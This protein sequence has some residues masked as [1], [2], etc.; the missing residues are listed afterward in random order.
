MT[1][2]IV[3]TQSVTTSPAQAQQR[4]FEETACSQPTALLA[5]PLALHV[6]SSPSSAVR[7]APS[8]EPGM[9][10]DL[11]VP[12]APPLLAVWL[13]SQGAARSSRQNMRC[14]RDS[15]RFCVARASTCSH[16]LGHSLHLFR[17]NHDDLQASVPTLYAPQQHRPTE[18]DVTHR[19]QL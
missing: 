6:C 14:W 8:L 16:S 3:S 18:Q 9:H 11:L 15:R 2:S 5:L 12:L 17:R 1:F 7:T 13:Q 4:A 19:L 10:S